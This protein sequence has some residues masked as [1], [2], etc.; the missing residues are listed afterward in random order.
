MT[1][2]GAR[3][4]TLAWLAPVP[5]F[6]ILCALAW[7]TAPT[8]ETGGCAQGILLGLLAMPFVYAAAVAT[9]WFVE[10]QLTKRR[11]NTFSRFAGVV[12]LIGMAPVLP[13]FVVGLWDGFMVSESAFMLTIA[14]ASAFL[15]AA[16]WWVVSHGFASDGSCPSQ[17]V[18]LPPNTSLER[19]REG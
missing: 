3:R 7:S 2:A 9:C 8:C 4:S 12:A 11:R 14:A 6:A 17:E 10:V 1:A 18:A 15:T 5:A 19:T 16:V 13:S